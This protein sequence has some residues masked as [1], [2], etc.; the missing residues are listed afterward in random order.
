MP[1]GNDVDAEAFVAI[2]RLQ[3]RIAYLER[4]NWHHFIAG[5][6]ICALSSWGL[7]AYWLFNGI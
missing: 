6:A 1:A 3:L 4:R 5:V 2:K 7:L